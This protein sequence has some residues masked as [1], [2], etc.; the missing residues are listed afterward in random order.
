MKILRMVIVLYL[1]MESM[2]LNRALRPGRVRY[3]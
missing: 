1:V 3:R 2:W